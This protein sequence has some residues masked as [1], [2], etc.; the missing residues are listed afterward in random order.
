M[1]KRAELSSSEARCIEENEL[2]RLLED[3][4]R[5]AKTM[6]EKAIGYEAYNYWYV[7]KR[8]I[9]DLIEEL[10]DVSKHV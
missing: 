5:E 10:K 9:E 3:K 6:V 2:S 1:K 8:V 7:R 4:L